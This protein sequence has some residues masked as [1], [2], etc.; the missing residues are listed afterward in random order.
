MVVEVAQILVEAAL[1]RG[2]AR[3]AART[4]AVI[5]VERFIRGVLS[6]AVAADVYETYS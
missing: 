3:D 1:E 2:R 5:R 6:E 4:S